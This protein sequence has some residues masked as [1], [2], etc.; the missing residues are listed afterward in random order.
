VWATF[1]AM[2]AMIR[3][4]ADPDICLFGATAVLLVCGIIKPSEAFAGGCKAARALASACK[5]PA[6]SCLFAPSTR[7]E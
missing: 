1:F 4:A 7:S 2:V 6:T 5:Q 3:E